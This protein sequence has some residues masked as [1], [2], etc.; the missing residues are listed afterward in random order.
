MLCNYIAATHPPLLT[1]IVGE[2][3]VSLWRSKDVLF[4]REQRSVEALGA[5]A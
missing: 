5:S 4:G 1:E 2:T 3:R